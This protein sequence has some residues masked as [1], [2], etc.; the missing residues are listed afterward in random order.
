MQRT[1]LLEIVV[2]QRPPALQ[3]LA[4]EDQALLVRRNALL[5]LDLTLHGFDR[6]RRLHVQRDRPARQRPHE[7]LHAA[8]DVPKEL[9]TLFPLHSDTSPRAVTPPL[10]ANSSDRAVAAPLTPLHVL[11]SVVGLLPASVS[12]R[13]AALATASVLPALTVPFSHQSP[14]TL[15]VLDSVLAPVT[16]SVADS[17][18][19]PASASVLPALTAPLSVRS[20]TTLSVFDSVVALRTPSVSDSAAAPATASVLPALTPF[21]RGLLARVVTPFTL[22]I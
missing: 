9:T 14:T 5:V 8:P 10:T 13:A 11:D 16:A 18:A 6:V 15:S 17:A 4:R 22:G 7:H 2:R 19:A 21:T 12:D 20:P 3:L 1:P